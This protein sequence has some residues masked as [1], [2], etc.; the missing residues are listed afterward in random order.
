M[1]CKKVEKVVFNYLY[2]ECEVDE[3]RLIKEHLDK[4]GDCRRES[5]IIADILSQLKETVTHDP[6]P[7]G[8][9]DRMLAKIHGS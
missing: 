6:V 8:L 9:R 4:C 2:G 5:E 1:D 3:L 7:E